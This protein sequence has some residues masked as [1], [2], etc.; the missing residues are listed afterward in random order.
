MK[1]NSSS[2]E[3]RTAL[4]S[5]PYIMRGDDETEIVDSMSNQF[6]SGKWTFE[7]ETYATCLIKEFEL[8]TLNGKYV[9]HNSNIFLCISS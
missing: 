8:G 4:R 7:E 6:R 2:R 1:P 5:S 3:R 9:Y